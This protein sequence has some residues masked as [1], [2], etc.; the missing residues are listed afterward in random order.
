MLR[1][2]NMQGNGKSIHQN[3][4]SSTGDLHGDTIDGRGRFFAENGKMEYD[5]EWKNQLYHGK[6]THFNVT[7]K[8]RIDPFDFR[9]FNSIGPYWLFYRGTFV[10]NL[11]E[12]EGLLVL[13]NSE[14][15]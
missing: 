10:K 13:T 6:G 5:G 3:G 4:S 15:Y 7:P 11:K 8:P 2:G 12:G 14:Y 1:S 9:N